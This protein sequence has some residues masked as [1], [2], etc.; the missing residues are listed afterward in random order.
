MG[1]YGWRKDN[2]DQRDFLAPP[3]PA[4]ALPPSVDLRKTGFEPPIYDQGD[5]GSCTSN[6]IAG[7]F[8]YDLKKQKLPD[9]APSRL[10]IYYNERELENTVQSDAGASIR[11]GFRS[12]GWQGVCPETDWPYDIA[13]FAAKPPPGAY[14]DALKNR[15]IKYMAVSQS[16]YTLR[17]VLWQ[18]FPIVFGFT[19]YESFESDAVAKT[20]IV[21]MPGP[22]ERVLG[23]HAVVAVGYENEVLICRNSWGAWGDQGHFYLPMQYAT[24]QLASDFWTIGAVT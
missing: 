4:V 15:A 18:G 14:A 17:Y 21:P 8:E 9:L 23:G 5:L 6:A 19:V 7:A 1:H 13:A 24:S 22:S 11:D 10:F 16:E 3:A 2:P 20:G 12:I